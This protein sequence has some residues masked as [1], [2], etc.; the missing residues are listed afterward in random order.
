V[1]VDALL[2]RAADIFPDKTAVISGGQRR[3]YRQLNT[4]ANRL[5]HE[6]RD[7]GIG[8][9]HRVA[10]QGGNSADTVVA[11]FAVA[12]AGAAFAVINPQSSAHLVAHLLQDSGATAMV[13][14]GV[15]AHS[16][17]GP[18]VF[19][20]DIL[21]A[22]EPPPDK[23]HGE[24]DLAALVYTSGSTGHAKG[25]MLSHGNLTAA[26]DSICQYLALTARDVILS[27]LPLAFTYGLGQVTTAFRAGATVVLESSSLYPRILLD[28]MERERVTG[29][30]I[31]PTLAT[32][33]LQQH[34]TP[35]S[36]PQLRYITNAAAA[37]PVPKLRR[38]R[39]AFPGAQIYSMYGQTECQRVS[40]LPP[41]CLDARPTSV[42]IPIP[43]TRAWIV[44]EQG[45]EVGDGVVGELVVSGPHVM[46]GYWN[47]PEESAKALR[48][49]RAT[50]ACV[51]YTNDLFTRD[52]EGF[53]YFVDRK[54][55]IIKTRGEKVA[56][57][58]VEEVIATLAGVAEVVVYGVPHDVLGEAVV[59]SVAVV[60]G[61]WLTASGVQRHC[62]EHLEP[63][64]VPHRVH[65]G[66]GL[67][68]TANGKVSRRTL[69]AAG[70]EQVQ[71]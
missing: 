39:E 1:T 25:V 18:R 30:P 12:K 5:A 66:T 64:M 63:F 38:L 14:A 4:A 16:L 24:D 28:T 55:D 37:L 62:L 36:F 48:R 33:I 51:L 42:G 22:A 29:L 26:A 35:G 45:T 23:R 68:V 60:P 31:V 20:T 58:Q 11:I 71:A 49:D 59:A 2:E 46:Q 27:V 69:R 56:P 21:A 61:A 47:Q 6:L 7:A 65:I 40:Y 43:G 53:L 50:G 41:D 52:A 44:D 54:D 8:A 32:L 15:A 17:P 67:P 13:G 57:R 3:T 19:T 9:G 10:I 34:I 70:A